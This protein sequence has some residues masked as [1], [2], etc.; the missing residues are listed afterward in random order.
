MA[1]KKI[2]CQKVDHYNRRDFIA[3]IRAMRGAGGSK[4]KAAEK[5]M[6]IIKSM[7]YGLSEFAK[8]TNHGESRI[9]NCVK[10]DL[11]GACRLVTVESE[12]V[13]WMLYVGDHE[14][15]DRWLDRNKGLTI[16][17]DRKTSQ[18]AYT[19]TGVAEDPDLILATSGIITEDNK[20]F[21]QRFDFPELVELVPQKRTQRDLLS[22][23]EETDEEEILEITE[24][25]SNPEVQALLL[26]MILLA[27]DGQYK[28]A[29]ARL[30][31]HFRDAI[32]ITED[33]SLIG[34]AL[35]S[36]ENSEGLIDF[37]SLPEEEIQRLMAPEG[38]E[39]W[40][41]FLHP[42]QK[43][44]VDEDYDLPCVL[45]GVSG[46]GKTVVLIHRARRLA[47]EYPDDKIGVLTLNRSLSVLLKNLIGKL[48]LKGECENIYVE[49]YY[50]YFQKIVQQLGAD[51]YLSDY[52][53]L[54]PENH[55]M[56]LTL[57]TALKEHQN[58][59][60]EFSP[61]SGETLKDTWQEFWND[62]LEKDHELAAIKKRLNDSVG[63]EF[64]LESYLRDEFVLIRSAFSREDRNKETEE[65]YYD[66]ERGGRCIP[67]N[68]RFRKMILRL[69]L[70]YEE[71]MFAGHM[72]DELG[73]G[74][75]IFPM[76]SQLTDLPESLKRR[77][78]LIDEFQ[79]FS[80]IELRLLKQIPTNRE[81]GLFLTG[82]VAQKVMV[83]DFNLSTALLDRSYVRTKTI[84][85]NYRNSKQILEAASMLVQHYVEDV[86]GADG[87]FEFLNPEY[88]V[89]E[90]SNPIAIESNH[91][92]EAAW[93]A[94]EEW[95]SN[96]CPAWSVCLAS[97]N[98]DDI[99]LDLIIGK[100]P[101]SINAKK[102]TGDYVEKK[103][104]V[105]V[106]TLSDVKGFEFSLII[107]V[108][109]SVKTLP[110]SRIPKAEQWRDALR[111][112]VAMTR[113][114]DQV[115]LTY[116]GKPSPFLD[117]MKE[118]LKWDVSEVA[119]RAIVPQVGPKMRPQA[120]VKV[121]LPST[122]SVRETQE[123]L[124]SIRFGEMKLTHGAEVL[125]R[126]YYE[127]RHYRPK[128]RGSGKG[129]HLQFNKAYG[130]WRKPV[131]IADI[132]VKELLHGHENRWDLLKE[133]D[134]ELKKNGFKLKR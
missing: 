105:S 85:K 55:P 106:C 84:R 48:C 113:G 109:C 8:L 125:L 66:Y 103:D 111:L 32:D 86:S 117:V 24:V 19:K 129:A 115:I 116:E 14:E 73:L 122:K 23:N 59:A 75:V 50:D 77:F 9:K 12:N 63:K 102:L 34:K 92:I 74:Q 60:R 97:A 101:E 53:R 40:M 96:G 91:A 94:A 41:L 132:N 49:S 87:S 81:N 57:S 118:K 119:E 131:N 2:V 37:A 68:A 126:S 78:L 21:L 20:P 114:R 71:Y 42:E 1:K 58:I 43:R 83:K 70:R 93:S 124:D 82:D 27:R 46:S 69:L 61:G 3:S 88:A 95:I 130:N 18:V 33:E 134:E 15:V 17:V 11:P 54:L 38:F 36:E 51:K 79:D 26:D 127:R 4:Q 121:K 30:K 28:D 90:T 107:V 13:I 25:I 112:Y 16:T 52:I 110:N 123:Q 99:A 5:V 104:T 22:I 67:F 64:D 31:L 72:L 108:G 62:E 29:K 120:P 10:Y 35:E 89:R 47:K 100:K 6:A 45:R 56:Q 65:G 44:V 98:E 7:E 133:I 76:I 128:H 39:D 80:T